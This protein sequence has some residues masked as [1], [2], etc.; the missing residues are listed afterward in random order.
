M[1]P[2]TEPQAALEKP[3]SPPDI[4]GLL[5]LDPVPGKPLLMLLAGLGVSH[6]APSA[7]VLL[8]FE[9]F[10]PSIACLYALLCSSPDCRL[11]EGRSE[12]DISL[13][14]WGNWFILCRCHTHQ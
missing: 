8:W 2:A 6:C 3:K 1:L 9:H 7:S 4:P 11:L 5:L 13:Y 14:P 10:S 12:A